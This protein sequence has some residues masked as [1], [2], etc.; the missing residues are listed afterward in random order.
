MKICR[1]VSYLFLILL[2]SYLDNKDN[3]STSAMEESWPFTLISVEADE[4]F[5]RRPSRYSTERVWLTADNKALGTEAKERTCLIAPTYPCFIALALEGSH[6]LE[7]SYGRDLALTAVVS[8]QLGA[9][10]TVDAG[11]ILQD[12]ASRT[13]EETNFFNRVE[14]LVRIASAQVELGNLRNAEKTIAGALDAAHSITDPEWRFWALALIPHAQAKLCNFN[15]ARTSIREAMISSQLITD[16]IAK[17]SA[18]SHLA[19]AQVAI[20]DVTEAKNNITKVVQYLIDIQDPYWRTELLSHIALLQN[21][22]GDVVGFDTSIQ[23][24]LRS[25]ESIDENWKYWRLAYIALVQSRANHINDAK[26]SV[27][28]VLAGLKSTSGSPKD[29]GWRPFAFAYLAEASLLVGS[30]TKKRK[31]ARDSV[32][33]SCA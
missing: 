29:M 3:W 16:E 9:G 32:S 8:A 10:M 21:R 5:N 13:D 14:I 26:E 12:V 25:V 4:W 1:I 23:L 2:L 7:S 15:Q 30:A 20:G 28:R 17:A 19:E 22:V 31:T 33:M 6:S 18:L 11:Q 27:S 24:A